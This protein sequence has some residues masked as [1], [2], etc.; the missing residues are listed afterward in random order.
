MDEISITS[1]DIYINQ[2]VK[3]GIKIYSKD[4]HSGM[5][6]NFI[7]YNNDDSEED[8]YMFINRKSLHLGEFNDSPYNGAI[9]VLK[10][11]L[12]D[13]KENG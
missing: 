8:Y 1:Q 3:C 6:D 13:E 11:L 9:S 12:N 5:L 2:D 10:G 7:T 4:T